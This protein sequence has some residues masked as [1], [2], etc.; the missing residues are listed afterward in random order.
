M[1]D[2]PFD[3][4]HPF[5]KRNK[6]IK[7]KPRDTD[8]QPTIGKPPV[9]DE[10]VGGNVVPVSEPVNKK[11]NELQVLNY[12][13]GN[14]FP[15]KEQ[16]FDYADTD[17]QPMIEKPYVDDEQVIGNVVTVSKKFNQIPNEIMQKC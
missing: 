17:K 3:D 4:G 15:A 16:E 12:E 14:L 1:M 9:E 11:P 6:V 8:N 5:K 13:P 7:Q 2:K 10:Q